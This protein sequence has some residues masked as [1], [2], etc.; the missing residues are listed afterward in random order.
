VGR[1]GAVAIDV[2]E[3]G[4]MVADDRALALHHGERE[5][6]REV[7]G[8]RELRERGVASGSPGGRMAAAVRP[9]FGRGAALRGWG[10]CG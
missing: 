6:E 4:S 5:R 9:T 1:H 10:S 3:A 8:G 2:V 7:S